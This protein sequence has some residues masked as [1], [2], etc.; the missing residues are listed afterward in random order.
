M[1]IRAAAKNSDSSNNVATQQDKG[2]GK[3]KPNFEDESMEEE[4]EDD[5]EN[6]EDEEEDEEEEEEE[7]EVRDASHSSFSPFSSVCYTRSKR[8]CH[9]LHQITL[10]FALV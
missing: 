8:N 9:R 5:E 3:V 4:M 2:K 1:I 7:E 10:P 6:D